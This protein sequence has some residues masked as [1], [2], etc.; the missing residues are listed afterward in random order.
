MSKTDKQGETYKTLVSGGNHSFK[1][2]V[3][4]AEGRYVKIISSPPDYLV[5]QMPNLLASFGIPANED[6]LRYDESKRVLSV[7]LTL[8][9]FTASA[10]SGGKTIANHVDEYVQQN[11][12]ARQYKPA[13]EQGAAHAGAR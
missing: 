13:P 12:S 8:D 3:A 6:V 5:E 11:N 4:G 10:D 1:S 2:N 9:Q 7:A